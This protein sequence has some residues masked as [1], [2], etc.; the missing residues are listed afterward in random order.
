VAL[1]IASV[2]FGVIFGAY[3]A[4]KLQGPLGLD[5]DDDTLLFWA[6][7]LALMAVLSPLRGRDA[8]RSQEAAAV[9]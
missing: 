9:I 3:V 1:K 4:Q 2:V 7:F 5:G 8:A 6:F